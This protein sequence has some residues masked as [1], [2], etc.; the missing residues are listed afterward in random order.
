MTRPAGE[1]GAVVTAAAESESFER[2]IRRRFGG[3]AEAMVAFARDLFA[4]EGERYAAE[5]DEADRLAL[6]A[7]SF[8]FFA[9]MPQAVRCRCWTPTFAADGWDSPYTIVESHLTDRP[10]IVDTLR[11]LLHE[12]RISVRHLVHPIYWAERDASGALLRLRSADPGVQ[13]ESFVHCAI[14]RLGEA[15]VAALEREVGERLEHVF[16]ATE[17]YRAMRQKLEAVRHEL[18]APSAAL[19]GPA[20]VG[21]IREF[22]GWL[23][24]GNFVFLGYARYAREAH[25]AEG[26]RRLDGASALGIL[27]IPS[28]AEAVERLDLAQDDRP[29]DRESPFVVTRSAVES[30]VHRAARM[31]VIVVRRLDAEGHSAGEHRFLG[32]FTSK[33]YAEVPAEVPVLRDKLRQVLVTEQALPESHDFR[34]IESIF[35]AMPKA[36]LL[37]LGADEIRAEIRTVRSMSVGEGVRVRLRP[38]GTGFWVTVI[39]PRDR[40]STQIRRDVEELLAAQL[41]GGV[42]DYQLT[43]GEGEQAR[44]HF[45][46]ADARAARPPRAEELEKWIGERVRSWEDR[47]RARLVAEHR[48]SRGRELAARYV[49][50]FPP[51]YQATTEIPAALNDVRH[52]ETLGG[53]GAVA[54]ELGNAVGADADRFNLLRLYFR[55]EG[56]VLSDFLPVLE[57]LG[58][59]VFGEDSVV[60]GHGEDRIVLYRFLVQDHHERRLDVRA[61]GP[62]IAP[63]ILAVHGGRAEN[64][65]LNQLVVDAGLGW[66]EVD[67]LR[68]YR[69]LAFQAGAAPSQ[70]ALNDVLIR[71]PAAARALFELFVARFDPKAGDR[72]ALSSAARQRVDEALEHTD[73]AVEDRMLRRLQALVENTLR[74]NFFRPE[75]AEHPFLCVK[76]RSEAIDFFPKPR[77]FCEIYVHSAR[78][79]GLHLR[80]GR[81]ARGGIRW[82][83]RADDF[84][85]EILG[86]MKTQMVKNAVIVPTGSKGGFVVKRPK[87]GDEGVAEVRECYATLMRGLL[88]LTDNVVR[89]ANVPPSQVVRH[90]GD[91]PYLVVA[92]DKGTATFSDLANS[93]AAEYQFWLGDAFASGGSHGYDHKKEGITARGAWECVA[94]H[95]RELGRD[96][97]NDPVEVVGIGDMSG[98]VFGNGMLLSPNVRLRAAFNHAHVFLDPTPDPERSFRERKRLF[99]LP[100][101]GWSDYDPKLLSAGGAIVSRN[102]K[103]ARLSAEVRAMLGVEAERLD[104]EGLVRAV[105][106]MKTDLLFNGGIGTYVRA[107]GESP[108]EVGD[109]GNDSVRR[110]A[111][112]VGTAVVGEGGNL[113][114]TQRARVEFALHGG[115]INTDA[116]D[117]SAGV[118]LSDHE[119]NLKILFQPLLESG[120]LSLAQRNRM[121]TEV[122]A[123]VVAHV[124]A[125]NTAQGL[126]LSL[127]QL[128]STTRLVE[129]RDQTAD[130]ERMGSLDRGL[131]A[132]PDREAL[133]QRRGR[134]RGLTRPELAVLAAYS[135][136][137]LK[138]ELVDS[139]WIDDPTFERYLFGYFPARILERFPQ[140]VRSHRLRKEIIATELANQTVDRLG[141]TFAQRM[142]RDTASDSPTAVASLVA[143]LGITEAERVFD[144][145]ATSPL[146]TED[147]YALALRWE[148]AVE[149]ACKRVMGMLDRPGA[150]GER[151][152]G[153]RRSVTELADLA[154]GAEADAEVDRLESLGLG[155]GIAR[156]LCA[157]EAL[158]H[159]LEIVRAAAEEAI[160]LADA[161]FLYGR[162]AERL[163]FAALEPWFAAVPG[164]DRWEKRAAEALRED[165]S[166]A[167][168]RLTARI[169]ALSRGDLAA[170]LRAF[171]AAHEGRIGPLRA[172]AEDLVSRHQVS[173]A[174]M[175]VFVREVWKFVGRD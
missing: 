10:F 140:A 3:D 38:H 86:L 35:N 4:R 121:L 151:A 169:H 120:E 112:E 84:R 118:D 167:H 96:L 30:P 163:G 77:P 69:N 147:A 19:V 60:L 54:V 14:D 17:D 1:S 50:L 83:D 94:R 164:D 23:A 97:R 31:E 150:L 100:R 36:E 133:R 47:L 101:S 65:S 119:V 162:V 110:T 24:D 75:R 12:R 131:E 26:G 27:R 64:D 81:V 73:T 40:F 88:E 80:G 116:I 165:L 128:R 32:L 132:L 142:Q 61:V 175:V 166:A 172:S 137:A 28:L 156:S 144:A 18:A 29:P 13:R 6:V 114:F 124:L 9:T 129:F 70:P 89:G 63:A 141:S 78:M 145:L 143:V 146:R 43:I 52:I 67:L 109:P 8:R 134:F 168:R 170:R 160:P 103:A 130:L 58:L 42:V 20:A 95:F 159:Q 108:A 115:R 106:G 148:A 82:S 48:G 46:V 123:E 127:D 93:I 153:W 5:L 76:V 171:V 92:A 87:P 49:S 154:P 53:P 155:A 117:N 157:L 174:A 138:R 158:P 7:S 71:R 22:L 122:K 51:Q 25:P 105:L 104:G 44:L 39:L 34:E 56:I 68:T 91:D 41:G 107:G 33:A 15:E 90:D 66:R 59:R 152:A 16:V 102:A 135:K 62:R 99:A 149:S 125:H 11:E 79:E 111:R 173:V 98:D 126:L 74:T 136:L 113:G 55:G 21:E 85:T 57:N 2:R 45:Y 139:P 161:A 72:E 37:M